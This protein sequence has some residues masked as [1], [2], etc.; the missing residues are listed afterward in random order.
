MGGNP[1]ARYVGLMMDGMVG[2]AYEQGLA[3]LKEILEGQPEPEPGP[4]IMEIP[5]SPEDSGAAQAESLAT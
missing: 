5:A 4:A 1:V 3:N 2:P